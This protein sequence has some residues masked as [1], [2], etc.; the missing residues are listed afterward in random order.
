MTTMLSVGRRMLMCDEP[1]FARSS[2]HSDKRAF[3]LDI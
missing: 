1:R 3:L 2:K